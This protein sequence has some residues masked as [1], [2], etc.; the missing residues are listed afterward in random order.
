MKRHWLTVGIIIVVIGG[1]VGFGMLNARRE[2]TQSNAGSETPAPSAPAPTPEATTNKTT[3]QYPLNQADSI[4]MIVNT[5]HPLP[6]DYSP[7]SLQTVGNEQLRSEAADNVTKL[8]AGAKTY[9]INLKIISG[10]R[11]YAAQ[12]SVYNSYVTRDGQTRADTYSARPGYSEHQ[13]GL[14][15]DLGHGNGQCDLEIC[16]ATSAGGMWL[17]AHAHDY[18]FVIRYAEDKT[19]ITGY[20]FE[21][22]HI[23]YVGTDLAAKV[24]SQKVSLEEYFGLPA[25]PSY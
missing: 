13:T 25:A 9:G 17:A 23:R 6:A 15:A 3:S 5:Q 20:Q 18:G 1:A 12:K 2:I 14:A 24:T 22:W 10:Y 21:P 4:W 7:T 11:S 16:F 19:A 8:I